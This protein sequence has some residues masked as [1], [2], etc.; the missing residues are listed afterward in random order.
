MRV[1]LYCE[2]SK[3]Y[4]GELT[5]YPQSGFDTDYTVETDLYLGSLLNLS[6]FYEKKCR[7]NAGEM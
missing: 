6:D 2:N 4:F 3:I 5:F 1:D 7:A